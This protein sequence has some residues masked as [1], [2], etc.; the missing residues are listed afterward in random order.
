MK[1][2]KPLRFKAL[3]VTLWLFFTCPWPLVQLLLLRPSLHG[4]WEAA[5]CSPDGAAVSLLTW[6]DLTES[7]LRY[8]EGGQCGCQGCIRCCKG[9]GRGEG[10]GKV[11]LKGWF[12]CWQFTWNPGWVW[13]WPMRRSYLRGK[14]WRTELAPESLRGCWRKRTKQ[15]TK[16][17]FKSPPQRKTRRE[18]L[19]GR[20]T[21]GTSVLIF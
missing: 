7:D 8:L 6:Q 14:L 12:F 17:A 19:P 20:G 11:N 3:V 15:L 2:N 10:S 16:E 9:S 21:W 1:G 5:S 13:R 4:A 18:L